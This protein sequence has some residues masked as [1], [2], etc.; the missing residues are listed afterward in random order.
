[1]TCLWGSLTLANIVGAKI[2]A[3]VATAELALGLINTN[4]FIC[5]GCYVTQAF[6][7]GIT[8]QNLIN[9]SAAIFGIEKTA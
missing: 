1:M 9:D 6:K 3:T 2:P 8:M 7:T 5:I 4:S